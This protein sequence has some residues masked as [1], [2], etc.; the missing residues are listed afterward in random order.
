MCEVLEF[1]VQGTSGSSFQGMVIYLLFLCIRL[2][3]L[4]I[5]KIWYIVFVGFICHEQVSKHF[6]SSSVA[7]RNL[8]MTT[9]R[10][11]SVVVNLATDVA[12]S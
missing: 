4:S 12:I 9:S 8:C 7:V 3:S 2:I 10:S 5:D 11:L 6:I 1:G